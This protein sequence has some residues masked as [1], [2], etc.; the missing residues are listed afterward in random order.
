MPLLAYLR[1]DYL[2]KMNPTAL[3]ATLRRNIPTTFGVTITWSK[4]RKDLPG[5]AELKMRFQ[6]GCELKIRLDADQWRLRVLSQP[7][8]L[9]TG[10]DLD[11]LAKILEQAGIADLELLRQPIDPPVSTKKERAPAPVARL[12][13][14][15]GERQRDLARGPRIA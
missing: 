5:V 14:A 13:L 9:P 6:S 2:V 1:R 3:S 7:S 4:V 8:G 10:R 15:Q 12:H 11:L